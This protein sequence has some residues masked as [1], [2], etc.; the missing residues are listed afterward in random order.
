MRRSCGTPRRR[1]P[2]P[3]PKEVFSLSLPITVSGPIPPRQVRRPYERLLR[4]LLNYPNRP[5]VVLMHGFRWFQIPVEGTGKFWTSGERQ[6]S[7]FGIFYG[8]PQLSLKACCYHYMV[9]G[10]RR[11]G[12]T[13]SRGGV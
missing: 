11:G 6:Q 8:L 5:A 13:R 12:W 10:E 4:K 2:S 1:E 7:E 9:E 3:T